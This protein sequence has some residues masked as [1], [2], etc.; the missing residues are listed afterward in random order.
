MDP[1]ERQRSPGSPAFAYVRA[2]IANGRVSFGAAVSIACAACVALQPSI[3]K[4][5]PQPLT[6]IATPTWTMKA[7][8]GD[9]DAP[10]PADFAA[11]VKGDGTIAFPEHVTAHVK[12]SSIMVDGD[13]VLTV[14]DDGAVK[15]VGLKHKY[16]FDADGALLD[17]QGRGVSI[18]PDGRVRAVGGPWRYPSVVVWT[19]DGG[20]EWDKSAWRT[21]EIVSLVLVENMIPSAIRSPDGGTARSDGGRERGLDIPPPSEWFK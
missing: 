11:T 20:G 7:A 13:V 19:T 1:L 6:P 10:Y 15:G 18:L 9:A 8:R 14:G 2:V 21:L 3:A 12:G 4:L 16:Q 17:D 5:S